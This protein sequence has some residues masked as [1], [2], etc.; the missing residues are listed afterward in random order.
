MRWLRRSKKANVLTDYRQVG[1]TV[2]AVRKCGSATQM[3]SAE[4]LQAARSYRPK[5]RLSGVSERIRGFVEHSRDTP[6]DVGADWKEPIPWEPRCVVALAAAMNSFVFVLVISETRGAWDFSLD[7]SLYT[8]YLWLGIAFVAC[9]VAVAIRM[10]KSVWQ[11][12]R[13]ELF[14]GALVGMV[15]AAYCC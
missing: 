4:A 13:A 1:D 9:E 15:A 7:L 14:G 10:W 2:R 3:S 12:P 8:I 5:Q 6:R 11:L